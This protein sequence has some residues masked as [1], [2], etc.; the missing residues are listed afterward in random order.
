MLY[1]QKYTP[2]HCLFYSFRTDLSYIA[3]FYQQAK[4]GEEQIDTGNLKKFIAR[5]RWLV[6]KNKKHK[7][8][9]NFILTFI[10]RRS[11]VVYYLNTQSVQSEDIL[12]L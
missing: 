4:I 2:P 1:S 11:N 8:R 6:R 3:F 10:Q 5:R 9:F 7:R 12:E